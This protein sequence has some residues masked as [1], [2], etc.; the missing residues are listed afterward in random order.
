MK[1]TCVDKSSPFVLFPTRRGYSWGASFT[2]WRY[3]S[4]NSSQLTPM[5]TITC[6]LIFIATPPTEENKPTCAHDSGPPSPHP[7]PFRAIPA[8]QHS[9]CCSASLP[10][11]H[12]HFTGARLD[13]LA[14]A[15]TYGAVP[16]LSSSVLRQSYIHTYADTRTLSN[17][18]FLSTWL[19][20]LMCWRLTKLAR[21]FCR[22]L[23]RT[24][25]SGPYPTVFQY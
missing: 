21:A 15:T 18:C 7:T 14:A 2:V 6:L 12:S 1:S 19:E 9:G 25:D 16:S 11:H 22:N 3:S 23:D 20:L 4:D 5:P 10:T 17:A 8:L 13:L 24:G